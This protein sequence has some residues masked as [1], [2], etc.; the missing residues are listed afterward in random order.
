VASM[1]ILYW[2]GSVLGALGFVST[3]NGYF[4]FF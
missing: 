1:P 3:L 2:A 4:L